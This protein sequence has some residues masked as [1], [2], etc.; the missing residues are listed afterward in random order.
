M[1]VNTDTY[2]G[3]MGEIELEYKRRQLELEAQT[4]LL[5]QQQLD[6]N[7]QISEF[8]I[9]RKR[10]LLRVEEEEARASKE[11]GELT[12]LRANLDSALQQHNLLPDSALTT[13]FLPLTDSSKTNFYVV[14]H[15]AYGNWCSAGT[16]NGTGFSLSPISPTSIHPNSQSAPQTLDNANHGSEQRQPSGQDFSQDQIV[17]AKQR[18]DDII[19]LRNELDER[20]SSIAK[21]TQAFQNKVKNFQH[22]G[23]GMLGNIPLVDFCLKHDK[24]RFEVIK[25]MG[26]DEPRAIELLE[27]DDEG[28]RGTYHPERMAMCQELKLNNTN[29]QRI[30]TMSE[31]QFTSAQTGEVIDCVQQLKLGPEQTNQLFGSTCH[32]FMTTPTF[33]LYNNLP[34]RRPIA[35]ALNQIQRN[36]T[37]WDGNVRYLQIEFKFPQLGGGSSSSSSSAVK[38]A[39]PTISANM[40]QSYDPYAATWLSPSQPSP[41]RV[42]SKSVQTHTTLVNFCTLLDALY[43]SPKSTKSNS[44]TNIARHPTDSQTPPT[45]IKPVFNEYLKPFMVGKLG[46]SAVGGQD[47]V[48]NTGKIPP[49]TP[50]LKLYFSTTTIANGAK[51]QFHGPGTPVFDLDK[52]NSA[53][54]YLGMLCP[55]GEMGKFTSADWWTNS[56]NGQHGSLEWDDVKN[57]WSNTG[58]S[59]SNYSITITWDE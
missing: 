44:N 48:N 19:R 3:K 50:K 15:N 46:N 22:L 23:I 11:R 58:E 8:E 30:L 41:T 14:P 9:E 57:Q 20:G 28:F 54:V 47:E 32:Q 51:I 36:F 56:Q 33:L 37:E 39:T 10:H 13:A 59:T 45:P 38:A 35:L 29:C 24:I 4:L 52:T 27:M 18:Y 5:K 25:I 26:L 55:K 12:Q 53:A 16:K 1:S 31:S 40:Y 49:L 42:A 34:H 2:I 7:Q 17:L 43:L 21:A 6:L